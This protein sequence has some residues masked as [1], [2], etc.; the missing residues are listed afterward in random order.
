MKDIVE[1]FGL[2][3]PSVD[4]FASKENRRSPKFWDTKVEAFKQDWGKE[5]LLWINPPFET[6]DE[7][8]DKIIADNAQAIVVVPKWPH[9]RWWH[10]L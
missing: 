4:A 5:P 6:L 2:N 9:R 1:T 8:V 10:K 3:V 7:V